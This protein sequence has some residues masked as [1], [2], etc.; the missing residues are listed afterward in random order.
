M[1]VH[2]P[3]M[4]IFFLA[5]FLTAFRTLSSSKASKLG[6]FLANI[7]CP[8]NKSEISFI[9]TPFVWGLIVD[10]ISGMSN[11]LAAFAA[12]IAA[13]LILGLSPEATPLNIAVW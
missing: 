6:I 13:F 8:G 10:M 12:H 7:S 11:I 4:T 2:K 3:D 5:A 1:L 9:N